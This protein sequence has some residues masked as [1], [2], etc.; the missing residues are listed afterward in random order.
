MLVVSAISL[1]FFC[2]VAENRASFI[3][4]ASPP[5]SGFTTYLVPSVVAASRPLPKF[6]APAQCTSWLLPG[7]CS[8]VATFAG[9]HTL[10]LCLFCSCVS[11]AP[12]S[13]SRRLRFPSPGLAIQVTQ[14]QNHRSYSKNKIMY[15]KTKTIGHIQRRKPVT[16][17]SM[18]VSITY[19]QRK[20]CHVGSVQR[21]SMKLCHAC[22]FSTKKVSGSS[23][24]KKTRKFDT[25]Y[26]E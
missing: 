24:G 14:F 11:S 15:A 9:L 6:R 3:A 23:S 22:R 7:L 2:L 21:R 1:F 18:K 26:S 12:S 17:K 8:F 20:L 5:D 4:H 25:L 16:L 19:I 13:S 10:V